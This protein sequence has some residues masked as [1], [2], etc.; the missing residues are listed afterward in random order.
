[1][2][3]LVEAVPSPTPILPPVVDPN[4]IIAKAALQ[5]ATVL[6]LLVLAIESLAFAYMV[7]FLIKS[8]I[9]DL[10]WADKY[11]KAMRL[12]NVAVTAGVALVVYRLD[13]TV[14]AAFAALI[15]AATAPILHDIVDGIRG[16]KK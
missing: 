8:A 16:L 2:L 15:G 13:G 11:L 4:L 10:M 12:L 6:G 1:M 5:G 14:L 3:L 7:T 9:K